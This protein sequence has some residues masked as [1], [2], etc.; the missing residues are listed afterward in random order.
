MILSFVLY[1]A[2]GLVLVLICA[3]LD[4]RFTFF[5]IDS[6]EMDGWMTSIHSLLIMSYSSYNLLTHRSMG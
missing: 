2:F 4:R 3:Y 1:V 5:T 6:F